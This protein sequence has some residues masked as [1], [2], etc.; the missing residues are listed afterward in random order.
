[1]R[2]SAAKTPIK[3]LYIFAA[4]LAVWIVII[5]LQLV[6]LQI[7]RYGEFLARLQRQTFRTI[8][9][10]PRRGYIYDRNGHQLAVSIDV[11]SVFAVPS[12]VHDRP[13]TAQLLG[14]V[15]NIDPQD[16][17]TRMAASKTFT[18]IAR[19]ID[20]DTSRAHSPA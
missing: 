12:E 8:P 9:V 1:M 20:D 11:D 19:K 13:T 14:R 6:R 15:L 3:R 17:M 2:A 18:F 5:I 7:F 10:E 16:I 4:V